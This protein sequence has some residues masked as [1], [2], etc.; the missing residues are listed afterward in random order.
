MRRVWRKTQVVRLATQRGAV[1]PIWSISRLANAIPIDLNNV[2][3]RKHFNAFVLGV[4]RIAGPV[5][6]KDIEIPHT[7]LRYRLLALPA[8]AKS[9]TNN[10]NAN[11][12]CPR[13]FVELGHE[14]MP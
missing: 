3:C 11:N 6:T 5:D 12:F 14:L 9:A 1:T 13:S 8:N 7:V 4:Q 2:Q 10:T